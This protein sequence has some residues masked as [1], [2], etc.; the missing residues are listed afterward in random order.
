MTEEQWT[1]TE[2]EVAKIRR[3]A[4]ERA[5]YEFTVW[6]FYR[7]KTET[8]TMA[9]TQLDTWQMLRYQHPLYDYSMQ[10][11]AMKTNTG[12]LQITNGMQIVKDTQH[13]YASRHLAMWFADLHRLTGAERYAMDIE[14]T[15]A[16]PVK[17]IE[18]VFGDLA[19]MQFSD[20]SGY[21]FEVNTGDDRGNWQSAYVLESVPDNNEIWQLLQ[22]EAGQ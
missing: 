21:Y 1:F 2:P 13:I 17:R 16:I 12:L 11:E 6:Y 9:V 14:D 4:Q 18:L 19:V 5:K 3:E 22:D 8:T 7:Y 15:K 20:K 10:F